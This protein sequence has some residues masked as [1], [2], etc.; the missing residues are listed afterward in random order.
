[1]HAND[2]MHVLSANFCHAIHLVSS[3]IIIYYITIA[4]FLSH[5]FRL[6]NWYNM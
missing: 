1:M 2:N 3:I 4:L 5:F 6:L